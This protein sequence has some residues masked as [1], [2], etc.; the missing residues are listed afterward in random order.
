MARK[1]RFTGR[2]VSAQ[3]KLEAKLYIGVLPERMSSQ[4]K[5]IIF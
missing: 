4:E 5:E 3:V 2:E 1:M